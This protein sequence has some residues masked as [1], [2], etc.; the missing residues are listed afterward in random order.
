MDDRRLSAIGPRQRGEKQGRRLVERDGNRLRIRRS[1]FSIR[2]M[3]VGLNSE[4]Q[5]HCVAGSSQRFSDQTTSS[6]VMVA[7]LWNLTP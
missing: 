3:P 6:A 7:P 4:R 1:I 2:A 5:R